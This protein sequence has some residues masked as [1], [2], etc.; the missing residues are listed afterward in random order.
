MTFRETRF[1]NGR[2]KL[3]IPSVC[4]KH[5]SG[6]A[7]V[8]LRENGNPHTTIYFP[9]NPMDLILVLG[10]AIDVYSSTVTETDSPE[11]EHAREQLLNLT[12]SKDAY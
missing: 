10:L 2:W 4:L 7:C 11:S 12:N 6:R 1:F 3:R 8:A 5:I 9:R